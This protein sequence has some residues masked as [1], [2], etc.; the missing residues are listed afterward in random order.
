MKIQ[1]MSLDKLR[2]VLKEYDNN[3][4]AALARLDFPAAKQLVKQISD[5]KKEIK[6]RKC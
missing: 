6:A 2:S 3:R 1:D 5:V 4:L